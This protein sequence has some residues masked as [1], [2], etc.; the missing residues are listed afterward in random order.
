M[1][2]HYFTKED[3]P[4]EPRVIC[5]CDICKAEKVKFLKHVL[6]RKDPDI[7]DLCRSCKMKENGISK[8]N[9]FSKEY[10]E[11]P[12]NK[13]KHANSIKHSEKYKESILK[14]DTQGENNG[15]Y[16]KT[17]S[18]E[19]IEQMRISRTGKKQSSET[20]SKRINTI[21]NKIEED[22]RTGK[23][24]IKSVNSM[25]K[26]YINSNFNWSKRVLERDN[27]KCKECSSSIKLDAHHIKPFSHII[28]ELC[29]NKIFETDIEKYS[30]L[31]D[32]PEL[33]DKDLHNGVCLCRECHKKVHINWG[34]HNIKINENKFKG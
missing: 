23:R 3:Y 6:S 32:Q 24:T 26:N 1:I 11:T 19:S 5:I 22:I 2:T 21:K 30:F 33:T 28:K 9:P 12:D 27:Y 4:G 10:W 16:G 7:K 31:I 25:V 34:S 8:N 17:H 15:M 29:K 18:D 14:R 20:I 13:L